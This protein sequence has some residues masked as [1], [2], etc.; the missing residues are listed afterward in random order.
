MITE[1]FY[2]S[3]IIGILGFAYA[4]IILPDVRIGFRFRLFVM[5]DKLRDLLLQRKIAQEQFD[6]LHGAINNSLAVLPFID[7][8]TMYRT[9]MIFRYSESVRKAAEIK[10]NIMN[11]CG[12][13]DYKAIRRDTN[14]IMMMALFWNC[15]YWFVL[16]VP[17]IAVK[18]WLGKVTSLV[19]K[20]TS[21]PDEE[22]N[23][24]TPCA[25]ATTA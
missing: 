1:L 22:I 19:L 21:F 14:K 13:E 2:W 5:R 6:A 15:G 11:S 18:V 17:I 4:G 12:D 16:I 7:I 20:I 8:R 9:Y 25:S 24:I 23:Q 3:V 10:I